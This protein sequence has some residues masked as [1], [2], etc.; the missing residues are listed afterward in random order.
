MSKTQ[1]DPVVPRLSRRDLSIGLLATMSVPS[2]M[3]AGAE[4]TDTGGEILRTPDDR[5]V[6]LPNYDFE[7][8]YFD[9]PYGRDGSLR[10]HYIDEGDRDAPA[11]LCLHGQSSWAY[12]YRDVIPILVDAGLRAVAPDYIGFG[13]SDKMASEEDYTFK[14][15][16]EWI[17]S[18][19]RGMAFNDVTAIMFDWGGYFGLR[20]A[21]ESPELFDRLVLSNTQLPTLEEGE[22]EWFLN[23]RKMILTAPEFP[24]GELVNGSVNIKLTLEEIAAY[25]A[26]FP[27]ES[28]KAGPRGFPMIHPITPYDAPIAPNRAAWAALANFNKPCLTL[29]SELIAKT[30]MPPELLQNHLPGAQGMPHVNIPNVGFYLMED[31]PEEFAR[32]IIDFIRSTRG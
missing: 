12:L 26:P 7:P 3:V 17:K 27:D 25:D 13:R 5:F 23:F 8:H 31:A 14:G 22:S 1:F 15:H 24:I 29:F 9:I 30:A 20:V 4:A 10:M 6:N 16:V 18:F 11:V 19:V 28:Y 21:G 32:N 2:L